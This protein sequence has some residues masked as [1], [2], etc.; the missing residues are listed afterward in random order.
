MLSINSPESHFLIWVSKWCYNGFYLILFYITSSW[1]SKSLILGCLHKQHVRACP[2][3][4]EVCAFHERQI[5]HLVFYRLILA[6]PVMIVKY[7]FVTSNFLVSYYWIVYRLLFWC[8]VY[9]FSLYGICCGDKH[10]QEKESGH[11]LFK[12][13]VQVLRSMIHYVTKMLNL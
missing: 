5:F 4:A 11:I 2:P 13:N 1:F 9:T 3:M 12:L 8:Q 6:Y 7:L 10:L